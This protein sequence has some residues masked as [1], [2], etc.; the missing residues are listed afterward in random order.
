MWHGYWN[1]EVTTSYCRCLDTMTPDRHHHSRPA[2]TNKWTPSIS[3]FQY[4]N[5]NRQTFKNYYYYIPWI[6][7]NCIVLTTGNLFRWIWNNYCN[8]LN[9]L[10]YT[11]LPWCNNW[12][13]HYLGVITTTTTKLAKNNCILN[14]VIMAIKIPYLIYLILPYLILRDLNPHLEH[15]GF[16]L[17]LLL[18][19]CCERLQELW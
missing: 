2:A 18:N 12:K 6:W 3:P 15:D 4:T 10:R 13:L 19:V 11:T 7:R 16:I 14:D 17:R 5:Q 9:Y 1:D 8:S